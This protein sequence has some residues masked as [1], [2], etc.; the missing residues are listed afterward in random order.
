MSG[1][2]VVVDYDPAWPRLYEEEARRVRAAF[3]DLVVEVEH[4]GST[5]VL[6]LSGKP[7]I[8]ISVGL[9]HLAIAPEHVRA[10]ERLGY[11]YLGEYGLP[12]RLYF[13]TETRHVHAVEWGG[14]R[15]QRHRAFR[16]YLR[17]H[18]DEARA[19]G[20]AK[21]RIAP[22]ARDSGD[23]WERKQEYVDALFE[24][25]WRWYERARLGPDGDRDN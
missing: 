4:M 1:R 3:G 9:A 14:E 2:V 8:D 22:L 12:G 16:D 15:W 19:Y 11:E 20:E 23:Y 13:R 21:R 6:G 18:P 25:A 5:A 24:R 17:A 7:L 10:M